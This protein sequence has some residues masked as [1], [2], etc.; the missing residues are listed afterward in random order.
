[1]LKPKSHFV[2]FFPMSE[3][4]RRPQITACT[5]YR[6]SWF[7]PRL[8]E[9]LRRFEHRERMEDVSQ[10]SLKLAEDDGRLL[11]QECVVII[12]KM[13]RPSGRNVTAASAWHP[14]RD[15]GVCPAC[16]RNAWD[17]TGQYCSN[18]A[19]QTNR[20]RLEEAKR[21][22]AAETCAQLRLDQLASSCLT[23]IEVP[24]P[25]THWL[26]SR[27]RLWGRTGL[28]F[29]VSCCSLRSLC[30]QVIAHSTCASATLDHDLLRRHRSHL[31]AYTS[32]VPSSP[33]TF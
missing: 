14:L 5:L 2:R 27:G 10:S 25:T 11:Y 9:V 24:A 4:C 23:N 33:S 1:L 18:A 20:E 17:W 15:V 21:R 16:R 22:F 12:V 13:R 8:A 31:V 19:T 26:L 3:T 7:F 29:A 32:L 6:R 30:C 28:W